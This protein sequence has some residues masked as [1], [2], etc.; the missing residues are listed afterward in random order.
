[1]GTEGAARPAGGRPLVLHADARRLL[2]AVGGRVVHVYC[3]DGTRPS[4]KPYREASA[5]LMRLLRSLLPAG[6][7]LEKASIDEAYI[8]VPPPP[9]PPAVAAAPAGPIEGAATAAAAVAAAAAS[10][11]AG[12]AAGPAQ[13]RA[14]V[15]LALQLGERIRR[16][17]R[18]QLGLSVSVGLAANKLLAKMA[19]RAAKPDGLRALLAA[20]E[21]RA[22]PAAALAERFGL[23]PAVAA[24]V[25]GWCRG[26]DARAVEERGPPKAIQVQM[27]L[28]PV[29]RAAPP[30]MVARAVNAG[31]E[32]GGGGGGGAAPAAAAAGRA[33]AGSAAAA[34]DAGSGAGGGGGVGAGGGGTLS[35]GGARG[36]MLLPLFPCSAEGRSRLG[37][38]VGSMARDLVARVLLDRQQE[39]RWPAKLA[40]QLVTHGPGG[41][42]AARTAAFPS[43][44]L[45]PPIRPAGGACL[46]A[47]GAS[48]GG[49][50][51]GG[52]PDGGGGSRGGGGQ[53]IVGEHS[54]FRP[55]EC[56][57]LL[58]AVGANAMALQLQ[59]QQQ[60]QEPPLVQVNLTAHSFGPRC[61]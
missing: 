45:A 9:P 55:E 42:T 1:M 22:L 38:L 5:A 2:A 50:G 60:Q 52:G 61:R 51:D 37:R 36:W 21:L 58:D 28:T 40:V 59:Q 48:G 34:E 29:P 54:E 14:S 35:S 17:A 25:A 15:Q 32:L 31:F 43:P 11:A 4:Y 27:T 6:A 39:R 24:A 26:E 13:G 20:D 33:G 7:V 57:R 30:H 49:G 53:L 12:G 19:S 47:G 41:R 56:S 8:L 46:A 18:A 23:R 3:E 16:E 10:V 44:A